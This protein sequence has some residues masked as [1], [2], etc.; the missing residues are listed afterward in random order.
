MTLAHHLAGVK[1]L[2][3]IPT[4]PTHEELGRMNNKGMP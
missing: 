3:L 1:P 2:R 4:R